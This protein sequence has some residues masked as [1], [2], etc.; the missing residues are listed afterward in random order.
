MS[1]FVL[2]L[3]Y[4]R[5]PVTLYYDLK[6]EWDEPIDEETQNE[7]EVFCNKVFTVPLKTGTEIFE[8]NWNC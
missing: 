8:S 7:L 5:K 1:G 6:A 3:E 2:I 4:S